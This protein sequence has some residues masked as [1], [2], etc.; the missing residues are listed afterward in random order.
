MTWSGYLS[1]L[2]AV[3]VFEFGAQAQ[4]E[5]SRSRMP[6]LRR[7]R[8]H[9]PGVTAAL[10]GLTGTSGAPSRSRHVVGRPTVPAGHAHWP[11][12]GHEA[13]GHYRNPAAFAFA[14]V[15]AAGH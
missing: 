7:V 8:R 1:A 14:P 4:P 15:S 5:A 13:N 6:L 12:E 10:P 3:V 11:G 9:S 2:L